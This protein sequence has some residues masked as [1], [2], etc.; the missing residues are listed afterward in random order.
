MKHLVAAI[1]FFQICGNDLVII[2][3]NQ[4]YA[5]CGTVTQLCKSLDIIDLMLIRQI[6]SCSTLKK[7]NVIE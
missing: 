1:M 2:K 6:S 3:N 4:P 7:F 5:V